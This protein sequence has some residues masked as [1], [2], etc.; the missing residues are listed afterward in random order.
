MG[1][2]AK[3]VHQLPGAATL[4]ESK[5]TLRIMAAID[6]EAHHVFEQGYSRV[7]EGSL[8]GGLLERDSLGLQELDAGRELRFRSVVMTPL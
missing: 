3:R 7:E 5:R 1:G 6:L 4:D 2:R 8:Q